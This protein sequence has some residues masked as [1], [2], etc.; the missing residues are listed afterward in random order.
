MSRATI[1]RVFPGGKDQLLREVGGVGDG[2]LLRLAG[3]GGRR[4]AGLRDRSSRTA[5]CSRTAPSREHV[6][7]QKI[8][9]TEPERLLPLL[10]TE[11]QRPLEFITGYL[12]PF[13]EREEREG[14]LLPGLDQARAADFVARMLL[15]LIGSDGDGHRRPGRPPPPR[16]RAAP[17]R[18][19]HPRSPRRRLTLL[20]RSGAVGGAGAPSTRTE[21]GIVM[22][23]GCNT[24]SI[25]STGMAAAPETQYAQSGDLSIAY[26]TIGDGPIDVLVVPGF[27]SNVELMWDRPA[28]AHTFRRIA[29]IGR[30]IVFDKRGTGC[31]DRSMGT[32]SAEERMDDLRAVADAAGVES[33]N[34]IGLSEGGP[35]AV[36]FAIDVPGAGPVV[37]VVGHVRPDALGAGLR[38]RARS[39][40]RGRLHRRRASQVG[41]GTSAPRLPGRHRRRASCRR[42]R[43]TS[44][45]PLHPVRPRPSCVTT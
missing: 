22:M 13:L 35:L 33:A 21:R 26:Q 28:L 5:C 23:R 24:D 36:L 44:A 37:G 30:L 12:M 41:D 25:H 45:R 16:A 32:G 2:S 39:R 29:E 40:A 34:L 15:S 1:Y 7:L 11:Q 43:A 14:R 4:R 31:S 8:L 9:V 18:R 19:P 10:T 27:V 3:R 17:R 42:W 20:T 6:V 38:G